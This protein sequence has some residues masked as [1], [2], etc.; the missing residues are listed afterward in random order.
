MATIG[1]KYAVADAFGR[2][3]TGV[4]AYGMWGLVHVM[5]LV[6]WGNRL[7][8]MYTWARA[9]Y[10]SK[11]RGHR[12]IT[13]EQAHHRLEEDRTGRGRPATI[14]PRAR[15]TGPTGPSAASQPLPPAAQQA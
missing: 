6:G 12:I 9:L 11:N 8:T 15:G 3:Y 1:H 13:F 14:L 7:G 5:Y 2:R 10:L 4:V